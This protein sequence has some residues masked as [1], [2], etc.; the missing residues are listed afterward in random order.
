M[1]SVFGPQGHF[2]LNFVRVNAAERFYIKLAGVSDPEMKRKIIGMKL[3][4]PRSESF[5]S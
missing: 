1:E 5:L 2:E 3:H 4:S